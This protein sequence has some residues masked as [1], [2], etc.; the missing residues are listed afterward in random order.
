MP[1]YIPDRSLLD[2][3]QLC[4]THLEL[5][6]PEPQITPDIGALHP[7]EDPLPYTATKLQEYT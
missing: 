6:S 5:Q 7:I 1:H 3:L 4:N 2:I